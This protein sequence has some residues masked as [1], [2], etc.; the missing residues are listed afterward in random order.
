MFGTSPVSS[1]SRNSRG[2]PVKSVFLL[3]VKSAVKSDV[4]CIEEDADPGQGAGH[5][6]RA[7]L[8]FLP[9]VSRFH[10]PVG[11]GGFAIQGQRSASLS[12]ATASVVGAPES[13]TRYRESELRETSSRFT[14]AG[15]TVDA[16]A[17]PQVR[18]FDDNGVTSTEDVR[19][20]EKVAL[21]RIY[22]QIQ[23]TIM[24]ADWH[25]IVPCAGCDSAARLLESPSIRSDSKCASHS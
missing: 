7:L 13:A 6:V 20:S 1:G 17:P 23:R 8:A 4:L 12:S 21:Q 2:Y 14:R 15:Y 10:V 11:R 3:L 18:L 16:R 5:D 19:A 22:H 24:K 25:V 9:C